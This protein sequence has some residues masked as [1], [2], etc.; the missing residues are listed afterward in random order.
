MKVQ[1]ENVKSTGQEENF[2][3]I[4]RCVNSIRD[5]KTI[6]EAFNKIQNE[7]KNIVFWKYGRGGS[8]I[9]ISNYKNERLLLITE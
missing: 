9:W 4:Q 8:H 3:V 5:T 1:I 7:M 6:H 2:E